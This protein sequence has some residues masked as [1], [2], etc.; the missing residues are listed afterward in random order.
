MCIN[1][2][3]KYSFDGIEESSNTRVCIGMLLVSF[4][5]L[6]FLYPYV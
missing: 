2:F 5:V 6:I 1:I 3:I 4:R